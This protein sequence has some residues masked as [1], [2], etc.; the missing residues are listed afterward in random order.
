MNEGYADAA[1]VYPA[2]V[3][4]LPGR[5]ARHNLLNYKPHKKEIYMRKKF[6]A[7][8]V[9]AAGLAFAGY[10]MV[11]SQKTIDLLS[12]LSLINMEAM[13]KDET[14]GT[15]CKWKS[16]DCPGIGTGDYEACLT[17][18]DGNSCSCVTVSRDCPK[19]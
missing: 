18:G 14:T 5:E 6:F 15:T 1:F 19:D 12:D 9:I 3:G 4:W 8:L 17:N 13:A 10:N 11:Q 7:A 2:G 16:T